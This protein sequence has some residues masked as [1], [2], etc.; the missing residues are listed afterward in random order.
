MKAVVVGGGVVGVTSAY[1]LARDGHE[2]TLVEK[3]AELATLA[4][5]GNAGIIAPGHSF[6]RASPTAPMEL[7]RSLTVED[8]ALRVNP[9][10]A[11]GMIEV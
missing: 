4:S 7:W 8:T 9:I 6:A 11:P 2:V 10:K 1:Y 3:E 5:A